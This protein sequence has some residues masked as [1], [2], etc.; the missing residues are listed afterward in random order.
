MFVRPYT[1][2]YHFGLYTHASRSSPGSVCTVTGYSWLVAFPETNE[3]RF[4]TRNRFVVVL[5][6]FPYVMLVVAELYSFKLRNRI[7]FESDTII[8]C[9][10]MDG[11]EIIPTSG[12]EDKMNVPFLMP[13]RL[14]L[15]CLIFRRIFEASQRQRRQKIEIPCTML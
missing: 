1:P 8:C 7:H 3:L 14:S 10:V 4:R 2:E 9:Q 6:F 11:M 15:L 13:D 5:P 12:E